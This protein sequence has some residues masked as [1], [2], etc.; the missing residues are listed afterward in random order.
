MCVYLC[1][2]MCLQGQAKWRCIISNLSEHGHC[3]SPARQSDHLRGFLV[4]GLKL[5][6]SPCMRLSLSL[7][8]LMP[9]SNTHKTPGSHGHHPLSPLPASSPL[10][11][12]CLLSFTSIGGKK[13]KVMKI[14]IGHGEWMR[15]R[16]TER[17][18]MN[19]LIWTLASGR[20]W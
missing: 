18:E 6:V 14:N 10:Y 12:S 15:E 4:Y 19:H 5:L 2:C 8:P 17:A 7:Y 16:E 3:S 9:L 1:A 20:L 11:H 13:D